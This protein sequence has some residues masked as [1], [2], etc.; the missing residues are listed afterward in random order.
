MGKKIWQFAHK[1]NMLQQH[2]WQKQ[3]PANH[4]EKN[5]T[6]PAPNP[7]LFLWAQGVSAVPCTRHHQQRRQL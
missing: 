6:S 2:E 3:M 7:K 1:S 4:R 5:P